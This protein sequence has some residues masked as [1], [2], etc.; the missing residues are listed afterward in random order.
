MS[1]IVT[2]C[3]G[4]N[5]LK[6]LTRRFIWFCSS[7]IYKIKLSNRVLQSPLSSLSL[8]A[9]LSPRDT[10]QQQHSKLFTSQSISPHSLC[11]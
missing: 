8:H 5:I 1:I 11:I 6:Q 10:L 9:S 3:P 7:K 2:R 4:R